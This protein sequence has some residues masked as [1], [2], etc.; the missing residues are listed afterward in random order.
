MIQF[1]TAQEDEGLPVFE[2]VQQNQFFLD[3]HG[4]FC[5]KNSETSYVVIAD[6]SGAPKSNLIKNIGALKVIR[7]IF[8]EVKRIEF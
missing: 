3:M 6:K 8:P 2:E 7:K 1:I 4:D 5:Q